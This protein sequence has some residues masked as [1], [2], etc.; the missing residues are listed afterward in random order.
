VVR[1]AAT[2][3]LHVIVILVS[4]GIAFEIVCA[5]VIVLQSRRGMQP[6]G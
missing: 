4:V 1:L 2:D 6:S 3:V 5:V